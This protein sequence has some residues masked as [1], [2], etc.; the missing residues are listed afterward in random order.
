MLSFLLDFL[1][2]RYS[3]DGEEGDW[4]TTEERRNLIA[5]V[6][7]T[8]EEELRSVGVQFL[9]RLTSAS[10]YDE[11]PLLRRAV[12]LF[13]YKRI[14]ALD[15]DLA[16]LLFQASDFLE[17]PD[18]L[19]LCPVPLHW[20]RK[21]ERGFNQSERLMELLCWEKG[22]P[23]EKL[24]RRKRATGHQAWRK[25]ADRFTALDDAFSFVGSYVPGR[26]LLI[27][28]I[29]TT[30]ATLDTCAKVLKEAGVRRVEGLVVARG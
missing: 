4:I 2:P 20:R 18:D 6:R 16:L 28:D 15:K 24:L 1:F 10:S 25:R 22:F 13:K 8:D 3:I 29:S 21:F 17:D 12:Q 11:E 23:C 9:D 26:V 27:D 30:G 19:V 5:R 7:M 14:A